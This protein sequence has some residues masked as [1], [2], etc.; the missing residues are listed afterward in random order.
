MEIYIHM[1]IYIF[2]LWSNRGVLEYTGWYHLRQHLKALHFSDS[3]YIPNQRW[4]SVL[5]NEDAKYWGRRG[6][7]T[8]L[9]GGKIYFHIST[10]QNIW[11]KSQTNPTPHLKGVV[12]WG[13]EISGYYTCHLICRLKKDC[14]LPAVTDIIKGINWLTFITE[15]MCVFCEVGTEYLN[16]I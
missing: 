6:V 15:T 14:V 5:S 2:Y 3:H 12:G 10:N 13:F 9:F 11:F 4:P 1:Y 7:S 16:T 8:P